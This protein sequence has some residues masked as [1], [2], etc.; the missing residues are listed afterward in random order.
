[1]DTAVLV[2]LTQKAL[3]LLALTSAPAVVA[4]GLVGLLIAVAQAATQLQDQSI[5]QSAKIG[6]VLLVLWV[7]GGWMSREIVE[8]GNELMRAMGAGRT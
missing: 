7:A 2:T 4:A 3:W 5:S 8:F 1:M 6:V